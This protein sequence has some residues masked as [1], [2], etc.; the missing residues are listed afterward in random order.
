MGYRSEVAWV[1]RFKDAEQMESYVNLL[2]FKNDEHIN[3]ALRDDIRQATDP[4]PIMFF[5]GDCLKWYD[6]FKDVQAHHY[7]M[8]HACELYGDEVGWLFFRIGDEHDDVEQRFDGD[9]DNMWDYIYVNRSIG[10][11][12][13]EGKAVIE[14]EE[15]TT[16]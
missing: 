15:E 2:R 5:T 11:S 8:E 7:I 3:E 6:E 10:G 4:E 12:L 13:P 1:L 9:T 16:K 14:T